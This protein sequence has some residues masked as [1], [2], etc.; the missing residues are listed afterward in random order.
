LRIL[1]SGRPPEQTVTLVQDDPTWALEY[2]HFKTLCEKGRP[3]DLSSDIWLNR[4]LRALGTE[5]QATIGA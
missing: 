1:P 2:E 4:T 3:T 5:A